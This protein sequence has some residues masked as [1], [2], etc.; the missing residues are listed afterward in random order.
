MHFL[1]P[2]SPLLFLLLFL[3]EHG[4]SQARLL[5]IPVSAWVQKPSNN[6]VTISCVFVPIR[7]FPSNPLINHIIVNIKV[8][9]KLALD[10]I[11]FNFQIKVILL[12]S[13]K[14]MQTDIL[15]SILRGPPNPEIL[16]PA[17]SQALF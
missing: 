2:A 14:R 6:T 8:I 17:I 11:P 3:L 9:L 16:S 13:G 10:T 7:L 5:C 1:P 12:L 4:P 15:L